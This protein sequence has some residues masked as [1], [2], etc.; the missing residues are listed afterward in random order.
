MKLFVFGSL[1]LDELGHFKGC[2]KDLLQTGSPEKLSLSFIVE[3]V[4]ESL[5]GCAGNVAYGLGLLGCSAVVIG[6][7]GHDGESYAKTLK[8]WG[9]DTRFVARS[10]KY[11]TAKATITSDATGAQI[12][13]FNPGAFGEEKAFILP[14]NAK[15]NDIFL[16][17][18]E[19]KNRM[20]EAAQ[21][22]KKAHLRLFLD[23]G[24]LLHTF[25]KK[26]LLEWM[27]GAEC[28]FLNEYEWSLL[29]SKTTLKEKDI[30]KKVKTLI[31]T[32]GAIGGTLLQK[33]GRFEWA[34]F[35]ARFVDGTGAGDAFRAAFLAALL[36]G[37]PFQK[38]IQWGAILGAAVVESPFAQGYSL[39]K[40]QALALKKL[41]WSESKPQP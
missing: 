3:E 7:L 15:P 23:P 40:A 29:Q 32:H 34:A 4:A 10:K 14:S 39:T 20:M 37:F 12:A 38:A 25:S 31:L 19:N 5:G 36:K 22:A 1:A 13:H 28:L 21:A 8:T 2:F 6:N 26:E 41:G 17:G 35:P 30:L 9:M 27:E 18:P 24:Q 16:L 33:E 11:R